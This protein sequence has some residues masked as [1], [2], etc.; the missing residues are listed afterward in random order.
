M[1]AALLISAPEPAR[2]V[3]EPLPVVAASSPK[4]TLLLDCDTNQKPRRVISPIAVSQDAVWQAYVEVEVRP[5]LGCEHTTRLWVAKAKGPYRLLYFMPPRRFAVENGMEILGWAPNSRLLLVQTEQW[6]FGS[7]APDT[8][9]V[10][11]IDTTGMVYEPRLE[12]MLENRKG[13]RCSFR[14]TDAGFGTGNNFI[15]LVRAN[16]FTFLEV[17]E[18]EAEVPAAE[19]CTNT[20]ETWSFNYADGEIKQVGNDEPLQVFRKFQPNQPK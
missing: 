20:E 3:E 18:T 12:E 9:Q 16:L 14:V 11:A 13:T 6:Q 19:R 10:L 1:C 4:D 17:L 7:D 15:V 8:Q 5:D 2:A